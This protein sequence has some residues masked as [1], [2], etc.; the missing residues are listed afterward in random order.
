MYNEKVLC[1]LGADLARTGRLSPSG[2]DRALLA[3]GRFLA[4]APGLKLSALAGVATAAVR[5]AEDGAVFRDRVA[6]ETNIRL[7]IAS[8]A[9]EARLAAQGVLFGDPSAAGLV[10]D[11]GGASM[12]L[13][14]VNAVGPGRGVTTPLVRRSWVTSRIWT[15]PETRSAR[16]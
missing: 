12:E 7:R 9:D 11:L 14:P 6:D 5:E 8:G 10:I 3:L 13:C 1:G 15:P 16:H 4:L 2:C